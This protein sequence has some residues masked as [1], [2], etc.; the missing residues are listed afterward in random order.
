MIGAWNL[1]YQFMVGIL[2]GT[3]PPYLLMPTRLPTSLTQGLNHTKADSAERLWGAPGRL[4]E[5]QYEG[6]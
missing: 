3:F 5:K 2:G 4:V 1:C 6:G